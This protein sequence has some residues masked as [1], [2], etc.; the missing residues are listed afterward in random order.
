[1]A[2]IL[3]HF[4]LAGL[5]PLGAARAHLEAEAAQAR[6]RRPQPLRRR[7]GQR[8]PARPHARRR[9]RRPA[10]GADRPGPGDGGPGGGERGGAPRHR[11]S[12]RRRPR[13]DGGVDDLLDLSRLRL[14]ARVGALRHQLPEPRR[15]LHADARPSERGRRRQAAAAHHHPGDAAARGAAGHAVRGHGQGQYQPTGHVRLLSNLLDFGMDPQE[16]IDAPR[17]FAWDGELQLE[18]GY[19]EDGGGR[20][21][22][23]R[24]PRRL[25][26]RRRSAA[27]RR[28]SSATTGCSPAPATR[29]RT[30]ARSAIER[31]PAARLG[32]RDGR[33]R[34]P[35][36]PRNP[37]PPARRGADGTQHRAHPRPARRHRRR[38]TGRT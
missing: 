9:D 25:A 16:A 17:S 35:R 33:H 11:L 24:P 20:A 32:S 2:K 19:D 6:L 37:L 14:G 34:R 36:H 8:H 21:R 1:M 29:A 30:A 10:G 5:D 15:R 27:R 26:R 12:L 23:A 22:R 28:S 7:S 3:G 31:P 13:P 18:T 4:D 38:A